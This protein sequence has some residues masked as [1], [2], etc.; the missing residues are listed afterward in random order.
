MNRVCPSRD[1]MNGGSHLRK[2]LA[3][4]LA[5]READRIGMAQPI[6]EGSGQRFLDVLSRRTHP[7][8]DGTEISELGSHIRCG[9]WRDDLGR[10][11]LLVGSILDSAGDIGHDRT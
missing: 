5:L 10:G 11:T 9:R 7:A 4:R 2:A 3:E 1:E 6:V 8:Q